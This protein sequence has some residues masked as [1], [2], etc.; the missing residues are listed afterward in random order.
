MENLANV[1]KSLYFLGLTSGEKKVQKATIDFTK[2]LSSAILKYQ[3]S[4]I[5][6]LRL[7]NFTQAIETRSVSKTFVWNGHWPNFGAGKRKSPEKVSSLR[8]CSIGINQFWLV[9][10]VGFFVFYWKEPFLV[11]PV[12]QPFQPSQRKGKRIEIDGLTPSDIAAIL[13]CLLQSQKETG[14][15]YTQG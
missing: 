8:T 4:F 9:E 13:F 14:D 12:E 7:E 6:V 5:K 10:L 2:Q 1:W 11:G 15:D 3:V